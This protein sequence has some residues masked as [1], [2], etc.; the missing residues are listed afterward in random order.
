M[1]DPCWCAQDPP[2]T[3]GWSLVCHFAPPPHEQ[4]S[5]SEANAEFLMLDAPHDRLT[6]G[7]ELYWFERA[8]GEQAR[9]VV[10]AP[11]LSTDANT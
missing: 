3:D 9:V 11:A 10:I 6:P 2:G 1:T 8:T 4:G 5:P 7:T